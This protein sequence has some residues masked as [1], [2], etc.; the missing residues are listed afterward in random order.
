MWFAP[1]QV[2]PGSLAWSAEGTAGVELGWGG[3][4]GVVHELDGRR[5]WK[6]IWM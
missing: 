6:P 4:M 1:S 2:F 5:G 3:G